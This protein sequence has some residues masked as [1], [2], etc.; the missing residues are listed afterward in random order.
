MSPADAADPKM[1]VVNIYRQRRRAEDDDASH[2]SYSSQSPRSLQQGTAVGR[3][4][5]LA[6]TSSAIMN[7]VALLTSATHEP[8]VTIRQRS[9]IIALFGPTFDIAIRCQRLVAVASTLLFVYG[10]VLAT[11]TLTSAV[12]A[13]RLVAAYSSHVARTTTSTLRGPLLLAWNSKRIRRLRKKFFMEFATTILGPGG[14]ML[15]VLVF[16]PGWMIVLGALLAVRML[17]K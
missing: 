11:S 3:E 17:A 13:S 5:T 8:G 16:W 12:V 10:H 15:L 2:A 1:P 14:N 7:K 4:H 6:E 9:E